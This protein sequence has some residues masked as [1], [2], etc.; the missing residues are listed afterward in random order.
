MIEHRDEK[1]NFRSAQSKIA[2]TMSGKAERVFPAYG[3]Q[4]TYKSKSGK[5]LAYSAAN[6]AAAKHDPGMQPRSAKR[7]KL[8]TIARG[9][10]DE[11]RKAYTKIGARFHKKG[12][13]HV[14]K[15][16]V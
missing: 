16:E 8:K 7:A 11:K 14:P 12:L 2:R 9:Q 13:L 4:H 15:V 10:A 6:M 3:T 1:G 5:H